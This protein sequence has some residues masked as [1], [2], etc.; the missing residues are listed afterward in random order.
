MYMMIC[1]LI[2]FLS[3]FLMDRH[4]C[5]HIKEFPRHRVAGIFP[6][7]LI[8]NYIVADYSSYHLSMCHTQKS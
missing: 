2:A 5:L 8:K 3:S 7:I 6:L 1:M 4:C